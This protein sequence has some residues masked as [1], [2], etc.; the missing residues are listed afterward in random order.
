MKKI[1]KKIPLFLFLTAV[2]CLITATFLSQENA[3]RFFYQTVWFKILWFSISIIL[4]TKVIDFF[5]KKRFSFVVIYLGF[6]F[7]LLGGFLTSFL[8]VEGYIE[9]SVGRAE[10][11][12]WIEDDL[13]RDL[14]FSFLVKDF[15]VEFYPAGG[16]DDISKEVYLQET[17][18]VHF[19]KAFKTSVAISEK[20][21]IVKEAIIKIN[22]PFKYNGYWFYQY[23]YDPQ[24]PKMTL[25]QVV[26]DPGLP[27][28]YFG[29]LFLLGGMV[30]SFKKIFFRI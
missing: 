18:G 24:R 22:K 2:V 30:F 8:G 15:S 23:A 4:F 11:L 16:D 29:Y 21:N 13:S 6:L 19:I 9:A 26:K 20:G 1:F 10:D 7:I 12:I 27:F 3:Q 5:K 28:V 14:G 17:N 25:I